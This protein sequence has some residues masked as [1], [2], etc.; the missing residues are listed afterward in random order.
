M[1]WPSTGTFEPTTN[2]ADGVRQLQARTVPLDHQAHAVVEVTQDA[3]ARVLFPYRTYRRCHRGD[4][5]SQQRIGTMSA[6][7]WRRRRRV[8][9]DPLRIANLPP[10]RQLTTLAVDSRNAKDGAPIPAALDEGVCQR[11]LVGRT[12]ST[13]PVEGRRRTSIQPD[14]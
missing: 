5:L 12:P 13:T 9:G 14:A 3:G 7:I 4:Q 11:L 10:R 2:T 1:P 6:S 8:S